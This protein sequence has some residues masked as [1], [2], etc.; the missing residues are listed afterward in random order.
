ML[1]AHCHLD[2]YS[3]PS[4]VAGEAA[5]RSVFTI[6]VTNLP[7]HFR[8]ALPHVRRLKSI[9]PAL[10]L[11]PLTASEH[12]AELNEFRSCLALTSF[13]GEVGLDFSKD[14]VGTRDI[15]LDSFRFVIDSTVRASKVL[16]LHS[17]RAESAVLD[18][19]AEK[20]APSAVFHWYSGPLGVLDEAVGRGDYFSVNPAMIRSKSGQQ[21]I[22]RIPAERVLTETDG[23]YVRMGSSPAKPWDVSRVEDYLAACWAV[24]VG[25]VRTRVW[26]NFRNLLARCGVCGSDGPS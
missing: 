14:G 17:R 6:A 11:H 24:P 4:V 19:L 9:R 13:V 23:P 5:D 1:D 21:I 22:A 8:A 16:S 12:A 25:D 26:S 3:D 10:G 18:I 20:S 15:Q 2:R 7:S